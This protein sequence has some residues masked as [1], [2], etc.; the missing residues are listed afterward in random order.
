MRRLLL[1]IEIIKKIQNYMI[2]YKGSN[3]VIDLLVVSPVFHL[4]PN[5]QFERS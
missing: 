2:N 4:P 1:F 3:A 5:M